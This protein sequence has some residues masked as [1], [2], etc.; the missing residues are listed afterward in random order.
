MSNTLTWGQKYNQKLEKTWLSVKKKL[1][2]NGLNPYG[3]SIDYRS[4]CDAASFWERDIERYIVPY[5]GKIIYNRNSYNPDWDNSDAPEVPD[6]TVGEFRGNLLHIG[7]AVDTG[8]NPLIL[9]NDQD[10]DL[11]AAV[12][13]VVDK[14]GWI[15]DKY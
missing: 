15:K 8:E 10:R 12:R 5:D 7:D 1:N 13:P 14:D 11:I 6:Q 9:A 2:E 3:L 4:F